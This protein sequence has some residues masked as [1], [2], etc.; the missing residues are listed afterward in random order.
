MKNIKK[1]EIKIM[2]IAAGFEYSNKFPAHSP[3]VSSE[4]NE[5]KRNNNQQPPIEFKEES[6]PSLGESLEDIPAFLRKKKK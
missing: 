3:F 1:G 2:I 5:I 6:A 4:K